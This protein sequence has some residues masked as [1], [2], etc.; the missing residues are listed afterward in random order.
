MD[1]KQ[2]RS[3][4][5]VADCGSFTQAAA[6]LYS[7]QPTVSAHVRQLEEEL[8]EQLFLRTT[9]TLSITPRGRE[10]YEYAVHVL[11]LQEKLLSDWKQDARTITLGVSTIPSAYILPEV[12]PPFRAQNPEL[13]FSIHQSDSAGILQSLRAGQFEL[14]LVG[15]EEP[16]DDLSFVPFYQDHMVLITP[17]TP[18]FTAL[19]AAGTPPQTLL[20]EQPLILRE[21]GSGSQKC[22]DAFLQAAG[23]DIASLCVTARLNDQESVKNL[24]A[25]GL[26]ISVISG[27][28][29]ERDCR[30]GQLL[31]FPLPEASSGRSLYLVWHKGASLRPQ[32]L[33]FVEFIRTFYG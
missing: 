26:G 33:R 28:A 20:R 5:A 12:L 23:L 7:S 4:V 31:A 1:F 27:K 22:V 30:A 16:A 8:H 25:G 14:G 3:F 24:V 6:R 18:H 11:A 29:A 10:L 13:S 2:L 21:A 17:N 32:V 15:M 9:K 19:L